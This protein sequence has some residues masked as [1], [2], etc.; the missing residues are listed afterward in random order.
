VK[1][2]CENMPANLDLMPVVFE[3]DALHPWPDR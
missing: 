2:V 1:V 3:A